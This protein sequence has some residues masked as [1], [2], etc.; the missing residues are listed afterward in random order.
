MRRCLFFG[1]VLRT[2][3]RVF[4]TLFS[5][6]APAFAYASSMP[7]SATAVAPYVISPQ[8]MGPLA[9]PVPPSGSA[10]AS[11]E[12]QLAAARQLIAASRFQQAATLL[13]ACLAVQ[14]ASPE[15]LYLLGE[16][17]LRLNNPAES[18]ADFT[19]AAALRRPTGEELRSWVLTTSCSTTTAMP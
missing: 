19:R 16:A 9:R 7:A 4:P 18:L 12:Q 5:L 1:P 3:L 15:P 10:P 14:P 8:E 6:L 13:R 17:E 2:A 11:E